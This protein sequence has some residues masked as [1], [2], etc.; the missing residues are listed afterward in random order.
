L[1]LKKG[2]ETEHNTQKQNKL[3]FNTSSASEGT[4]EDKLLCSYLTNI[5]SSAG[6]FTS[7][8]SA[9]GNSIRYF[10]LAICHENLTSQ[11]KAEP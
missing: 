5:G 2:Y 10:S 6:N 7:H 8:V 4:S 9:E 11:M 1:N 3:Q